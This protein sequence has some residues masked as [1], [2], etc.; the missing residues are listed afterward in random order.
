MVLGR[1]PPTDALGGQLTVGYEAV[2]VWRRGHL[3]A[4]DLKKALDHGG[5]HLV[6]LLTGG[7]WWEAELLD[8]C[9]A[10]GLSR[11][12]RSYAHGVWTHPTDQAITPVP[13]LITEWADGGD[14]RTATSAPELDV[15]FGL[16]AVHA[17]A[18]AV[19]Q[20]HGRRI[21]HCD[22]R[23]S[24]GLLIDRRVKLSDLDHAIDLAATSTIVDP[25]NVS[26]LAPPEV[27]YGSLRPTQAGLRAVDLYLL[28]SLL[29]SVL[30]RAPLT[31]LW[32]GCLGD[33]VQPARH[34]GP[35]SQVLP[36]VRKAFNDAL[37]F[38]ETQIPNACDPP[39]VIALVR[40]LS[41]PDP[42]RRGH[43]RSRAGRGD[44]LALARIVTEIDLIRRRA[45]IHR[46]VP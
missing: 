28:G 2:S 24:S 40:M 45:E 16:A 30:V 32:I 39:R 10:E 12:V 46:H 5:L 43:P 29:L 31:T 18:C 3:K 15:C 13:Y 41:D 11:I 21:A 34:S 4:L 38:A 7:Q 6:H 26:H 1:L 42:D 19:Q 25:Q 22:L 17:I 44:P 8:R 9:A 27:L 33:A 36:L 35:L 37:A 20:L 23:L 14:L